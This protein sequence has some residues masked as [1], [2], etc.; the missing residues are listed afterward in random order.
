[1]PMHFVPFSRLKYKSTEDYKYRQDILFDLKQQQIK[2]KDPVRFIELR[3]LM[4]LVPSK[5]YHPGSDP[6]LPVQKYYRKFHL[7][8]YIFLTLTLTHTHTHTYTHTHTPP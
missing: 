5:K 2:Q 1:M 7:P 4:Y 8:L 3:Y 6:G